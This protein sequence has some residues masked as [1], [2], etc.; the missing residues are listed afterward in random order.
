MLRA[1]GAVGLAA[2]IGLGGFAV[3]AGAASTS[4]ALDLGILGHRDLFGRE[5][6]VDHEQRHI[7]DA[8]L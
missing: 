4:V 5:A 8:D 7:S 6:L 1:I 2:A 3:V